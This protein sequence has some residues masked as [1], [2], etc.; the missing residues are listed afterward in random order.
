[1]FLYS[2]YH[3]LS[4]LLQQAP[5]GLPLPG[6]ERVGVRGFGSISSVG[7]PS[8]DALRASTSPLRGEVEPSPTVAIQ[9]F[10][11]PWPE[12]ICATPAS[13][14]RKASSNEARRPLQW[15]GTP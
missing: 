3:R 5:L 14:S 11:S 1:L 6:G 13:A 4:L 7:T 12:R 8:P 10:G 2:G 9:F 15:C